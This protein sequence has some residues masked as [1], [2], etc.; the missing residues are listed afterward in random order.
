MHAA[1][2]RDFLAGRLGSLQL[3]HDLGKA[4]ELP[5]EP[6]LPFD[7][8]DE[9]FDLFPRHLLALCEAVELREIEPVVLSRVS[10]VLAGSGSFRW[11]RT[12][13]DGRV[14][15]DVLVEWSRQ[16]PAAL[17]AEAMPLFRDWLVTRRRP[18][19]LGVLR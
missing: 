19:R 4:A 1:V 6:V 12:D 15:E 16:A 8:L 5:G 13:P 3:L 9:P 14:V 11:T 7:P 10:R 18:E 2:L 17:E